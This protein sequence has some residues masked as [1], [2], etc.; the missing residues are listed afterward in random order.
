[1]IHRAILVGRVID[2]GRM[3]GAK[4]INISDLQYSFIKKEDFPRVFSENEILNC[5]YDNGRLRSKSK[6]VHLK[7]LSIYNK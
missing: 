2:N 3:I 7:T 1:M 6:W 5:T 4:F